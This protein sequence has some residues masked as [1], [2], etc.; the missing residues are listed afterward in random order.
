[1]AADDSIV[2]VSVLVAPASTANSPGETLIV[3][4]AGAV[5]STR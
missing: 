2:I 1:L 5:V 4:P 3:E